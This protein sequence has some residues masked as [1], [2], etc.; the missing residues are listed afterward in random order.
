[1]QDKAA[2]AHRAHGRSAITI[3]ET[4]IVIFIIA[5]LLQLL[6]PAVQS[7]RASARKKQCMNNVH[8]LSIG[9]LLH[10][11]AHGF[12]PSGGWSGAYTCDPNRGYGREQPGGWLYSL[13]AYIDEADLR[14]TGKGESM[15]SPTLGPGLKQLHESAPE[16]FY[17]PIRRIAR[18]YPPVSS[19]QAEWGLIVAKEVQYL[20]GV[21]KSD[22]AA[23]TG[24]ALHHAASSFGATMWWPESYEA[25]KEEPPQ[26]TDTNDP[27]SEFYQSGVIFYRSEIGPAKITDG[28]AK[29]Y[30]IG[31]KYMDPA[32]YEDVN[33]VPEYARMGDNQ[34][35]WAG[36]EWDNQRVAWREGTL[37]REQCYQPQ[38]D[39][40]AVCPAIWAFGSA[41]A[42]SMNMA[43]CDGSV[44]E[45]SYD[46][47]RNVHRHFA[48]RLD[49]ESD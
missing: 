41:H 31:E 28:M 25:L 3:I 30:L 18:P 22:Y 10:L 5:I 36:F 42:L 8:Q 7:G 37:K 21:T 38:Q 16:L 26:W 13:L 39:S 45:I 1:M 47:D 49:G 46:I 20:P 44:R 12:L 40:G 19:G 32:T 35:A 48:N 27:H 14:D 17:C 2:N 6:L 15:M 33:N 43:F 4:L 24:D 29:T 9:A 23:N 34:S 11:N